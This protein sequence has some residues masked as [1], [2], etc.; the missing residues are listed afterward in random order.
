M[1]GNSTDLSTLPVST[2]FLNVWV[3]RFRG[4]VFPSWAF[5]PLALLY[6]LFLVLLG[7]LVVVAAAY[8]FSGVTSPDW[9]LARGWAIL[10]LAAL[11]WALVNLNWANQAAGRFERRAANSHLAIAVGC[12]LIVLGIHSVL[13]ARSIASGPIVM[14]YSGAPQAGGDSVAAVVLPEGNADE[15]GKI[16]STS[17]VTCH[18]PTGGGLPNLAPSLRGSTFVAS[19]DDAAVANVIRMGRAVGTPNNKSGKVMPARGGNPF[20]GDDKI[21]HLVAFVRAIQKEGAGGASDATASDAAPAVQLARWVVP[22]SEP[23]PSGMVPLAARA[24]IGDAE[25]LALRSEQRRQRLIS[26]TTLGLA[27][28]HGLFLVGVM[29]V[30]MSLLCRRLADQEQGERAWWGLS[31]IGWVIATVTWLAVFLFGFVTL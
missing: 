17:C 2:R 7:L 27:G 21:V 22:P 12:G 13:V 1:S 25:T 9:N 23:P 26:S 19:A 8:P 6:L 14:D 20:L 30:S 28:I 11:F 10:S 18:G 5:V 29:V 31:E 4:F 16:F 24:D 15:G 3:A